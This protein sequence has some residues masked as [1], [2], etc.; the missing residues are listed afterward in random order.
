MEGLALAADAVEDG[1]TRL[2]WFRMSRWCPDDR[3]RK[4]G[5]KG[6]SPV[7][8]RSFEEDRR[9]FNA[10]R[11]ADVRYVDSKP[12]VDAGAPMQ[13]AYDAARA[14]GEANRGAGT[15]AGRPSMWSCLEHNAQGNL[16]RLKFRCTA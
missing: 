13:M 7:R 12:F 3:D 5:W 16:N 11:D 4:D 10:I 15:Q 9:S 2:G 8:P 14:Y 1:I 6:F